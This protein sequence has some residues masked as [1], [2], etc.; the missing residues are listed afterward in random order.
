MADEEAVADERGAAVERDRA[1]VEPDRVA[2]EPDRAVAARRVLHHVLPPADP[3]HLAAL[4]QRRLALREE[5]HVH[6]QAL[7]PVVEA[8]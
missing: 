3:R 8:R 2:V 7:D 6:R 1:A 5:A 4:R